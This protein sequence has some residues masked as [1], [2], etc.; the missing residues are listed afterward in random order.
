MKVKPWQSSMLNENVPTIQENFIVI[1]NVNDI[2]VVL[3]RVPA[4]VTI[5]IIGIV[6][7]MDVVRLPD[8][9]L[10]RVHQGEDRVLDR[11]P[12][13]HDDDVRVPRPHGVRAPHHEDA[14]AVDHQAPDEEITK[15]FGDKAQYYAIMLFPDRM[16]IDR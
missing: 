13:H 4:V 10:D 8:D 11:V 15:S 2:L 5:G 7:A 9:A 14:R 6:A 12:H 3:V 1:D 16:M